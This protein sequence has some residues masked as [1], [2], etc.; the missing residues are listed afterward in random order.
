MFA[1]FGRSL[2]GQGGPTRGSKVFNTIFQME[3]ATFAKTHKLSTAR[4]TSSNHLRLQR[5]MRLLSAANNQATRRN[6]IIK[7]YL[8]LD[9]S[10]NRYAPR[11]PQQETAASPKRASLVY[12]PRDWYG[13]ENKNKTTTQKCHAEICEPGGNKCT[14]RKPRLPTILQ[15]LPNVSKVAG[16]WRSCVLVS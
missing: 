16:V 7:S 6:E 4:N 3:A 10:S 1:N 13:T 12:H 15:R 14:M 9:S 8:Q 11:L 2:E 5:L